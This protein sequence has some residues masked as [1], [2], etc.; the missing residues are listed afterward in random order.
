MF[1]PAFESEESYAAWQ[2]QAYERVH[3]LFPAQAK[4]YQAQEQKLTCNSDSRQ[5]Q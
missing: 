1:T 4:A 2:R 5:A 3:V